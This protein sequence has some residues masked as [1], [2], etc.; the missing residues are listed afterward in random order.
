MLKKLSL[1]LSLLLVV[2]FFSSGCAVNRATATL[3][4]TAD[5]VDIDSIY[6]TK[7]ALDKRGVNLLIVDKLKSMGYTVSTGD[8]TPS[9]VDVVVTYKDKWMW[10]ITMY[11]IELTVTIRDSK[12]NFPLAS[13]NSYH[14]SLTR[15]SPEEMVSEVIDNIFKQGDRD[16]KE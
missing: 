16:G 4:P 13:G 3:D 12:T 11:M 2:I 6:V 8:D 14:T 10:D 5:L 15:K 1:S 7:L 9:S